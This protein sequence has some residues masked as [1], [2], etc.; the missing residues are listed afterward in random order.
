M[1]CSVLWLLAFPSKVLKECPHSGVEF[2]IMQDEMRN[3]DFNPSINNN[4]FF[5]YLYPEGN[6]EVRLQFVAAAAG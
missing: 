6:F 1:F 3:C 2:E 4:Q 5:I